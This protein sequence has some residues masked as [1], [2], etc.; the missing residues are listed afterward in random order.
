M[1]CLYQ[2][3]TR[4]FRDYAL[5]GLSRIRKQCGRI[6]RLFCGTRMELERF[7]TIRRREV[8]DERQYEVRQG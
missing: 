7:L 8:E 6:G 3:Q 1:I 4:C 5:P 2:I